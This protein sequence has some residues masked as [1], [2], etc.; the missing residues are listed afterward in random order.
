GTSTP[1]ENRLLDDHYN[2]YLQHS[3]FEATPEHIARARQTNHAAIQT[4]IQREQQTGK[5]RRALRTWT[6]IAA[7]VVLAT[8]MTLIYQRKGATPDT[9]TI[10]DIP[11]GGN[12]ALLTLGDGR[13]ID[14]SSAQDGIV[15]GK[16]GISYA[17]GTEVVSPDVS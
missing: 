1:E 7:M 13:Q 10:A 12:K 15:V 6:S 11:P 14:L 2:R 8:T 5:R 17:D 16:D 9:E 3:P 4:Y